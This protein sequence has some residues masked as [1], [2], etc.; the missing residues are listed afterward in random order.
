MTHNIEQYKHFNEIGKDMSLRN[1]IGFIS[2]DDLDGLVSY[3]NM[4]NFITNVIFTNSWMAELEITNPNHI[5]KSYIGVHSNS[6]D[7]SKISSIVVEKHVNDIKILTS[8]K[9]VIFTSVGD[10]DKINAIDK[11]IENNVDFI[12]ITDLGITDENDAMFKYLKEKDLLSKVIYIDHHKT[13]LSDEDKSKFKGYI[14]NTTLSASKIVFDLL[15]TND[16]IAKI[17]ETGV[18]VEDVNRWDMFSFLNKE[19][20]DKLTK[21]SYIQKLCGIK[22]LEDIYE[23]TDKLS[24]SVISEYNTITDI[25]LNKYKNIL[26]TQSINNIRQFESLKP[27]IESGS[28]IVTDNLNNKILILRQIGPYSIVSKWILEDY[29]DIDVVIW[30]YEGND[31]T[32]LSFRSSSNSKVSAIE[33]LNKIKSIF[34]IENGGGHTLACGMTMPEFIVNSSFSIQKLI[35]DVLANKTNNDKLCKLCGN[36]PEIIR[37]KQSEM[38]VEGESCTYKETVFFCTEEKE[39]FTDAEFLNK[40]LNNARNAYRKKVGLLTSD[41]IINIRKEL[42]ISDTELSIAIGESNDAI[43]VIEEKAIQSKKIDNAIREY[44]SK[45]KQ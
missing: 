18:F 43:F 31:R 23:A 8:D 41:E 25:I 27:I 29:K 7:A 38:D 10:K 32:T 19:D 20:E 26:D 1:T 39:E 44:Y 42:K 4:K 35:T 34:N 40:N 16:T 11:H 45:H 6:I 36:H 5:I 9:N 15:D 22:F 17:T 12:C 13:N 30:I 21:L 33:I 28:K 14:N 24:K 37:T 2:H 3:V